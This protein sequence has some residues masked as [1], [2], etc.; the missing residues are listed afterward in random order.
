[1][2]KTGSATSGELQ[3]VPLVQMISERIIVRASNPGQFDNLE[4]VTESNGGSGPWCKDTATGTVYHIGKYRKME[5]RPNS[6]RV[7]LILKVMRC[8]SKLNH[9]HR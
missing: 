5:Q 1:M 2:I 8:Y 3:V 9:F 7:T 4:L 6:S